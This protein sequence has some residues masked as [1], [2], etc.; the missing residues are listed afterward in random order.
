[1][2]I[3]HYGVIDIDIEKSVGIDSEGGGFPC[4][5]DFST[6]LLFFDSI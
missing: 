6:G 2:E 1:M 3:E 5:I 4:D